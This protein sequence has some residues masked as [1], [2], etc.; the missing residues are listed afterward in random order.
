[1]SLRVVLKKDVVSRIMIERGYTWRSL[2][3]VAGVSTITTSRAE[4]GAKMLP[5]TV[6]KIADA[7][8]VSSLEIS[9]AV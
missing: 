1:M 3:E 4:K 7:L 5:T 8:D 9:E 2:A 6:K